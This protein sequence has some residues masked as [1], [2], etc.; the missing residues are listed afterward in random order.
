MIT[1]RDS[2]MQVSCERFGGASPGQLAALHSMHPKIVERRV[3][4][5]IRSGLLTRLPATSG[6]TGR[7]GSLLVPST[8]ALRALGRPTSGARS[9][10]LVNV[11]HRVASNDV[12]IA[13]IVAAR[14]S[15]LGTQYL[16]EAEC[17]RSIVAAPCP[18]GA[19]LLAREGRASLVYVECDLG[20][21][22]VIGTKNR[23]SIASKLAAYS[24]LH[25]SGTFPLPD[26][27]SSELHGF[28]CLFAVKGSKRVEHI[29]HAA[30]ASARPEIFWV[31]TLDNALSADVLTGA[32][33]RTCAHRDPQPLV[34]P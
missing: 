16:T 3:R 2:E 15:G 4:E 34:R 14:S 24:S 6:S 8:T 10:S 12:L 29:L 20:T 31:T 18:D 30:A 25:A 32:I 23:A 26:G 1:P 22:V 19:V 13:M 5:M 11:A 17:R 7:P 21:E 9:D 28:R 27:V 33:W